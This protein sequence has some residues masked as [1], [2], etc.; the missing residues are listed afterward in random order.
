[1]ATFREKISNTKWKS[2]LVLVAILLVGLL[3]LLALVWV[4][5]TFSLPDYNYPQDPGY[6]VGL[7]VGILAVSIPFVAHGR[8]MLIERDNR[9][10]EGNSMS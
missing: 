4:P 7:G 3:Y 6:W 1:M 2:L 5:T 9:A 8:S 10:D